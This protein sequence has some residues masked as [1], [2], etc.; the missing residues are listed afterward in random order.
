VADGAALAGGA[1][2]VASAFLPWIADGPGKSLHG[3]SFIDAVIA[4]GNTHVS[5]VPAA[6]LAVFWYAIPALGALMWLA[7]GATGVASRITR[8]LA[9]AT[10]LLT[11]VTLLAFGRVAGFD[12]LASGPYVAVAGALLVTAGAVS[13]VDRD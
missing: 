9:A 12:N 7:V 13:P 1:V 10:V 5:G 8:L 4:L 2:L 11:T 6:R 3:H